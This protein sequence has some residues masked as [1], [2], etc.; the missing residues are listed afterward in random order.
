MAVEEEVVEAEAAV[1][2][3]V[4]TGPPVALDSVEHPELEQVMG[5]PLLPE[6]MADI[7]EVEG[8]VV[9]VEG[10]VT[11]IPGGEAIPS[12]TQHDGRAFSF[13]HETP[14]NPNTSASHHHAS[15]PM[16]RLLVH[17]GFLPALLS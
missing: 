2:P 6:A 9:V 5:H 15:P 12:P 8:S 3:V 1:E 14:A 4:I 10:V 13:S 17:F 11:A 16:H 7:V